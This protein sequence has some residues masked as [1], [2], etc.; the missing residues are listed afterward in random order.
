M[1]ESWLSGDWEIKELAN[2]CAEALDELDE[3]FTRNGS[4]SNVAWAVPKTLGP[5]LIDKS[6]VYLTE[7]MKNPV[8]ENIKTISDFCFVAMC[9][10]DDLEKS[11]W[12]FIMCTKEEK[13]PTGWAPSGPGYVYLCTV[14][15]S[16]DFIKNGKRRCDRYWNKHRR[17]NTAYYFTVDDRTGEVYPC[18]RKVSGRH[19]EID[20]GWSQPIKLSDNETLDLKASIVMG[21]NLYPMIAAHWRFSAKRH[22]RRFKKHPLRVHAVIDP[23]TVV[24]LFKGR[25]KTKATVTSRGRRRPILHWSASHFRTLYYK[26]KNWLQAFV[27]RLFPG[28]K[29]IRKVVPVRT[30]LRGLKHFFCNSLECSIDVPREL[31]VSEPLVAYEIE[32]RPPPRLFDPTGDEGVS[33]STFHVPRLHSRPAKRYSGAWRYA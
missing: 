14:A 26:P 12:T 10:E 13:L 2:Q 17:M 16:Y 11:K 4:L 9:C 21:F 15:W 22:T 18:R 30:H 24:R 23:S 5:L 6:L 1:G 19:W 31:P 7:S 33:D 8:I 32:G 28:L 25:E 20:A 3:K 29:R 27:W